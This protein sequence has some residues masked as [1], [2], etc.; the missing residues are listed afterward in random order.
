V[1][2]V[3]KDILRGVGDALLSTVTTTIAFTTAQ[4]VTDALTEFSSYIRAF[5]IVNTDQVNPLTYRQGGR[6]EPLKTVPQNSEVVS[7]GWE[8][9]LEINP[10]GATGVGFLEMDLVDRFAALRESIPAA[11]K[12]E[13]AQ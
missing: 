13:Q 3:N 9:F 1:S 7:E 2:Y 5:R 11:I 8:S 10:D 6:S 4:F 12:Q